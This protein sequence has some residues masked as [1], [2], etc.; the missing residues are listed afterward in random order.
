MSSDGRIKSIGSLTDVLEED[1]ISREELS[2]EHEALDTDQ[3]EEQISEGKPMEDTLKQ[4]GKLTMEEERQEGNISMSSCKLGVPLHLMAP[5]IY[6]RE[7]SPRRY[8]WPYPAPVLDPS[9]RSPTVE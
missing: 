8:G 7:P 1:L 5:L 6:I 4:A 3:A 2:H 9:C